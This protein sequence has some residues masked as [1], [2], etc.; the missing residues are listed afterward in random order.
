MRPTEPGRLSTVTS[1]SRRA[2]L[3]VA[4]AGGGMLVGSAKKTNAA[5][6]VGAANS[7]PRPDAVGLTPWIRI[8][9]DNQIT[10]LVSQ[11]DLRQRISTTLPALAVDALGRARSRANLQTQNCDH[12]F[13]N[14]TLKCMFHG[15]SDSVQS[16]YDLM[17]HL[18]AVARPMTVHGQAVPWNL[19]APE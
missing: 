1:L 11:A 4:L 19:A 7:S 5:R 9:P 16:S 8:T 6:L 14:P 17:R 15:N 12:L 10:I 18:R 13:R 3:C 2:F